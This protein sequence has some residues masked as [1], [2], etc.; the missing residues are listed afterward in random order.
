MSSCQVVSKSKKY[1]L[2]KMRRL[3]VEIG[4]QVYK[5]ILKL[6]THFHRC[7]GCPQCSLFR[8]QYEI[9]AQ[10]YTIQEAKIN[11]GGQD[12]NTTAA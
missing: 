9:D 7:N 11:S 5:F 1:P 6:A 12:P 2:I 4:F 3:V 8:F 10:R